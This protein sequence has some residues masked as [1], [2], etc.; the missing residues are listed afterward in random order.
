MYLSLLI[1]SGCQ[2]RANVDQ[3][4]L[5]EVDSGNQL[6]YVGNYKSKLVKPKKV[7][8]YSNTYNYKPVDYTIDSNGAFLLTKDNLV[9]AVLS[10]SGSLKISSKTIK[11]NCNRIMLISGG[12]NL[13]IYGD[14][15]VW[16]LSTNL[17]VDMY[18]SNQLIFNT[19]VNYVFDDGSTII[20]VTNDGIA[21]CYDKSNMDQLWESVPVNKFIHTIIHVCKI[22]NDLL[23]V[24]GQGQLVY[25]DVY[26]GAVKK[27]EPIMGQSDTSKISATNLEDILIISNGNNILIKQPDEVQVYSI[28]G[29][30]KLFSSNS[31]VVL[32]SDHNYLISDYDHIKIGQY[33]GKIQK[34]KGC[35]G[36]Q[37]TKNT[38]CLVFKNKVEIYNPNGKLI[39]MIPKARNTKVLTPKYDDTLGIDLVL[40]TGDGI[41]SYNNL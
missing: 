35:N 22:G 14:K 8:S 4:S 28:S 16:I 6:I 7:I 20:L 1:L 36:V 19:P 11:N 13:I 40:Q 30:Q 24:N 12:K 10:K 17:N 39:K 25:I 31:F 34:T 5:V 33:F 38:V 18:I 26:T 23:I 37:F 3:W 27:I 32:E 2:R 21:S 9:R 29:I 15:K 41:E